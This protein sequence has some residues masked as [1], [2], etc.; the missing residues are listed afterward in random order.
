MLL[1]IHTEKEDASRSLSEKKQYMRDLDD[2][3]DKE[4]EGESVE[5][6]PFL[7]QKS[8]IVREKHENFGYLAG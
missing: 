5:P 6:V 4:N 7:R 8:Q 1:Y 2:S 3:E